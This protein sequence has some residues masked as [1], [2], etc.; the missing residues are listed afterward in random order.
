MYLKGD[1]VQHKVIHKDEIIRLIVRLTLDFLLDSNYIQLLKTT[2]KLLVNY[3]LDVVRLLVEEGT[4]PLH[5][6]LLV[7]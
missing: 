6:R 1:I 7:L 4:I 5:I 2:R 3:S